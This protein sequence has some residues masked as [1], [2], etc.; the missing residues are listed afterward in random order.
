MGYIQVWDL[1]TYDK[2][3]GLS[4]KMVTLYLKNYKNLASQKKLNSFN[5]DSRATK[6]ELD[7]PNLIAYNMFMVGCPYMYISPEKRLSFFCSLFEMQKVVL[8]P[9]NTNLFF[10]LI[11]KGVIF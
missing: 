5:F 6:F 11:K 1:S 7:V 9:K 4:E 10:D 8:S 3:R 2:V